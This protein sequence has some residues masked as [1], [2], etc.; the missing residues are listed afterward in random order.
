MLKKLIF[1]IV[2]VVLLAGLGITL[3][4]LRRETPAA[5]ASSFPELA[6]LDY[7][8]NYRDEEFAGLASVTIHNEKGDFSV[9]PGD[10]PSIPGWESL[11]PSTYPLTRILDIC[12]GLISQG[13]VVEDAEDLS[14][15][16]LDQGRAQVE[17]KTNSGDGTT[18]YVGNEAPDNNSVYVRLGESPQVYRAG[19]WEIDNLL[20]GIFDFMDKEVSPQLASDDSGSFD[21]SEIALGGTV[22]PDGPIRVVPVGE[23][24][25]SSKSRI[26]SLYRIKSPVEMSLNLDRG[27]PILQAIPG[28]QA[29]SV[30]ARV[31]GPEDLARYGLDK[32]YSTAAISGTLGQGLGGFAL[33]ASAPDAN[34]NV[35][36]YR[37]AS[38]LV[39]QVAASNLTW[40]SASWWDLMD[41]MIIL[42]FIDQVAR[43]EVISPQRQ[44]AFH[45]S[46]EEDELKVESGGTVLN[47][48]DFRKYYQTLLSA[49][50]D[51]YG[52]ERIPA[53]ATP[54]LE[55]VYYY[56]ENLTP[57]RVS[58]YATNSRRVLTSLNGRRPFYTYS[59][60][61]EWVLNDLDKILRGNKVQSY[62]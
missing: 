53:G 29:D 62:L 31:Y 43:V 2:M 23:E 58:F 59:A 32:P 49:V 55:I 51:E 22:R 11:I 40:L 27:L 38:E 52:E 45:L 56:R 61:V 13:L 24:E 42:P 41:K 21:F 16:G 39:Y 15:Y 8:I 35:Y 6:P 19:K 4:L 10:P 12:A 18:L 20:Q 44:V 36:I 7:L 28:L 3:V 54:L 46:G 1:I 60:Y 33:R 47:T 30:I 48:D 17:I 9:L 50:Y 25:S 26:S 5:T 37:E 34:G 14:I 57:D